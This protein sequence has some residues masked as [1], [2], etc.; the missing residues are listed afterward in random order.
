MTK[1]LTTEGVLKIYRLSWNDNY[2]LAQIARKCGISEGYVGEIKHG[3]AYGNITGHVK[4]TIP[5]LACKP[6]KKPEMS[7]NMEQ[8]FARLLPCTDAALVIDEKYWLLFHEFGE[9]TA[10]EFKQRIYENRGAVGRKLKIPEIE[11]L[12]QQFRKTA[13][14]KVKA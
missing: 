10:D 5:A 1:K 2:T 6:K 9:E 4:G 7:M 8:K 13:L 3:R 11:E 14:K 12:F